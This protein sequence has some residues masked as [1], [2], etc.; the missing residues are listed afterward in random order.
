VARTGADGYRTEILADGHPLVSDEP[1]SA[2]GTNTGPSPYE[3]LAAA[4]GACTGITLRMYADRKEWPLD[5]VEVSVRH[6]KR[7]CD[8]CADAASGEP[9]MDHLHRELRFEGD[10]DEEQRGR[11]REIADR[12]PVHRTLRSE[13]DISTELVDD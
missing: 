2:G 1:V 4:L 13:V 11:L 12:C 9:M 3:L 8:D 10:L 6:E 5:E 7:H